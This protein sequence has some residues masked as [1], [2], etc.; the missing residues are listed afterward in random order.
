MDFKLS[1]EPELLR[2]EARKLAREV[3]KD[4]AARWDRNAEVPWDNLHLL[5][6]QGYFGL[7]IPEQYG[8]TGAT[9]M[10]LV[11]VLEEF[12]WACVSTTMYVFSFVASR[13]Q[14][15]P[16]RSSAT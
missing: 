11:L 8:G 12:G 13:S 16:P 5:A 4:R 9:L 1:Q 6:R 2:N 10:D 15:A 7:M 14:A 3:F